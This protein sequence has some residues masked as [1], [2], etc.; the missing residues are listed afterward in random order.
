[1]TLLTQHCEYRI[2]SNPIVSDT[3]DVPAYSVTTGTCTSMLIP[4]KIMDSD[5]SLS[6]RVSTLLL[7]TSV[8]TL[9]CIFKCRI[10]R[11][12]KEIEARNAQRLAAKSYA[13]T[14]E[15]VPPL[16]ELTEIPGCECFRVLLHVLHR[17]IA[18]GD[19]CGFA[20]GGCLPIC[21]TSSSLPFV[22]QFD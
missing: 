16:S 17:N 11:T 6:H 5:P 20:P 19:P 22:L 7:S 2:V 12:K 14:L 8:I 18:S 4:E 15:T 3:I 13:N 21:R 9:C 1:M 10:P